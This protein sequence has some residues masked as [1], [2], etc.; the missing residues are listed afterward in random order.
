MPTAATTRHATAA[1]FTPVVASPA[2][3]VMAVAS[4]WNTGPVNCSSVPPP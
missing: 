3:S 4:Q 2:A 1:I